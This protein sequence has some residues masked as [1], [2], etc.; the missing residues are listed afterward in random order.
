MLRRLDEKIGGISYSYKPGL[1]GQSASYVSDSV[2]VTC[3]HM[4]RHVAIFRFER[5]DPKWSD[6]FRKDGMDPIG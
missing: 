5:F 2:W 4:G 3:D 6:H 1:P